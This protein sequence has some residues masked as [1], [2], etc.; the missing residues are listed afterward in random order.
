MEILNDKTLR[1]KHIAKLKDTELGND[2][3]D[4]TPKARWQKKKRTSWILKNI[5]RQKTLLETFLVV[6]WLR[7][8]LAMQETWIRS[9]VGELRCHMLWGNWE[10][11]P[12]ES[13]CSTMKSLHATTKIRCSQTNVLQR[14][15]SQS[16]KATHKMWENT[17]KSYIWEGTNIQNIQKTQKLNN[18]KN[19]KNRKR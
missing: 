9:L 15:Y 8:C 14:H 4:V 19:F 2:V 16:K 10:H 6:Q 17:C 5:V 13:Q 3:L 7:I 12:V 11:I 18:N 1:R